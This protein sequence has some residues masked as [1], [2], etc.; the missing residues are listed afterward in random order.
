[1]KDFENQCSA[2]NISE[3]S[4]GKI[5]PM[6]FCPYHGSDGGKA[7]V[8]QMNLKTLWRF[9]VFYLRDTLLMP[10]GKNGSTGWIAENQDG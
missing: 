4:D 5:L 3:G 9:T 2:C 10:N 8:L 1:M 7:I 6:I